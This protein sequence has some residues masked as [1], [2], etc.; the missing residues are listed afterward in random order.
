MNEENIIDNFVCLINGCAGSRTFA[1][2][3]AKKY[4]ILV[5]RIMN[6]SQK[7]IAPDGNTSVQCSRG[8]KKKLSCGMKMYF[9]YKYLT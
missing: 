3:P 2:A 4:R 9:T 8:K 5:S 7:N 1:L 6:R